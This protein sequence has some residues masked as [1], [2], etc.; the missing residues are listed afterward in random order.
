MRS[1]QV[2]NS[3]IEMS[4]L[5]QTGKLHLPIP[6]QNQTKQKLHN[7][8]KILHFI[9]S[10]EKKTAPEHHIV[11]RNIPNETTPNHSDHRSLHSNSE[12]FNFE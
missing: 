3:K 4:F 1:E 11:T 10:A 7:Y 12:S 6:D 2:F 9:T 5:A 8:T